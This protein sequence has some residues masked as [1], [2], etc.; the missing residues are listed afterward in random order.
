MGKP[1]EW[2]NLD[3]VRGEAMH[4]DC[5]PPKLRGTRDINRYVSEIVEEGNGAA[6]VQLSYWQAQSLVELSGGWLPVGKIKWFYLRRKDILSQAISLY[7]SA[8]T[9]YWHSYQGSS[10]RLGNL[11]FDPERCT[12]R[13]AELIAAE[14]KFEEMFA[15]CGISPCRLLYEDIQIDPLGSL[16][17]FAAAIGRDVPKSLPG[18]ELRLLRNSQ[19]DSW[20]HE[21]E[22][23]YRVAEI[24]SARPG[25]ATNSA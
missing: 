25:I 11:S 15:S 3:F 18:T 2:F 22:A 5:K 14:I 23:S 24:L 20:R 10:N 21:L 13:L 6:G 8:A 19:T 16:Q 17:S 4:L 7:K 1:Q 9:G 12:G